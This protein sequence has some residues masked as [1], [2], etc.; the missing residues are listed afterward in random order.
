MGGCSPSHPHAPFSASGTWFRPARSARF[1]CLSLTQPTSPPPPPPPPPHHTHTH[2]PPHTP[3]P[4]PPHPTHTPPHPTPPHPTPPHPTRHRSAS[5]RGV[6]APTSSSP[7][8][9]WAG[10]SQSPTWAC[11]GWTSF[12][13]S[14]TRR[15]CGAGLRAVGGCGCCCCCCCCCCC[16]AAAGSA[17]SLASG[18]KT[19]S[20]IPPSQP[21]RPASWRWE[22]RG[23]WR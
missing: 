12:T 17:L 2:T 20:S 8:S 22:E 21:R 13:Q 1:C 14:S 18:L 5:W 19:S 23:R 7:R 9:S 6:P 15:R 4:T 3:H 16:A 10:P 11:L